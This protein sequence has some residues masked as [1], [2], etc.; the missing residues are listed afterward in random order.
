FVFP[1]SG[2]QFG[3]MGRE[4]ALQWPEVLRRQDAENAH[5]AS[6]M[7]PDLFWTGR[8][9]AEALSDHR[10]LICGQ[11]TFGTMMA[12][13]AMHFGLK[14]DAAIGYSLGESTALLALRAWRDRD[15]MLERLS[16]SS[17]FATDL[18]GGPDWVTGMVDR[19][20]EQVRAAFGNRRDV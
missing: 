17:L 13:L 14:P 8:L 6:Q 12:D 16:A 20:P 2:N 7:R 3:D 19:A 15:A 5:L 4:L 9:G 11:V 18:A 10:A 1:G